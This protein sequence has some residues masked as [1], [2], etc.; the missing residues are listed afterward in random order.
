M[1]N[2]TSYHLKT[3]SLNFDLRIYPRQIRQWRGAFVNMA[4][5]ENDLLHNHKVEGGVHRRYPMVQYRV[6]N[7]RAGVF[8]IDKGIQAVQDVVA[9]FNWNTQWQGRPRTL[10]M[11][12]LNLEDHPIHMLPQLRPYRLMD[13]IPLNSNNYNEWLQADSYIE[14]IQLL[15]RLLVGNIFAFAN[16]LEWRLPERL[17]V[18]I[19][20]INKMRKVKIHDTERIA[21]NIIYKSNLAIPPN[22]ALGK[23]TSFGYGV[24]R[25]TLWNGET[26]PQ[27]GKPLQKPTS[28]NNKEEP[29]AGK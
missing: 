12:H 1:N 14:R 6:I 3:L 23:G 18:K 20:N 7:G 29:Q 17:E 8:A 10:Q 27:A 15:E 5:R 11:G 16:A 28:T 24:Q 22:I 9:S 21:F 13:W 19:L 26:I 4:G 25:P 2:S